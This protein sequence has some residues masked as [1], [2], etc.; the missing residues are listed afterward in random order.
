MGYLAG[1]YRSKHWIAFDGFAQ[2][3]PM[4]DNGLFEC[5]VHSEPAVG[6]TKESHAIGVG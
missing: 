1:L 3:A 5:F 2:H 6:K 4:A